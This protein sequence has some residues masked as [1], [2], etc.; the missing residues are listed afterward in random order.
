MAEQLKALMA[1]HNLAPADVER[2]TGQD[3][4]TAVSAVTVRRI[5][6]IEARTEPEPGTLRRIAEAVGEKFTV[7]FAEN[8]AEGTVTI[9][10]SQR[11]GRFFVRFLGGTPPAGLD[12]DLRKVLERYEKKAHKSR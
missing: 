6:K 10:V 8:D 12:A 4:R 7:A 9:D 1:R 11:G 5:I 3:G 2:L